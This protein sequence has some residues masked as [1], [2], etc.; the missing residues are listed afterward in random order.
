M[1]GMFWLVLGQFLAEFVVVYSVH[2]L[3]RRV[4][5]A[6]LVKQ[7]ADEDV[8]VR[9]TRA[10]WIVDVGLGTNLEELIEV[11]GAQLVVAA[12]LRGLDAPPGPKASLAD[13]IESSYAASSSRLRTSYVLHSVGGSSPSMSAC[14]K[15]VA[16]AR[17]VSQYILRP[18]SRACIGTLCAF[19]NGE[20]AEGASASKCTRTSAI[21]SCSRS[22]TA[23]CAAYRHAFWPVSIMRRTSL[24]ERSVAR[25]IL[26]LKRGDVRHRVQQKARRVWG[27]FGVRTSAVS[28]YLRGVPSPV[29]GA[30]AA[31]SFQLRDLRVHEVH[32]LGIVIRHLDRAQLVEGVLDEARLRGARNLV[33]LLAFVARC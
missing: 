8:L 33:L 9:E 24:A 5:H 23:R 22:G 1:S 27:L 30:L 7:L 13:M 25:G 20:E 2:I 3:F 14:W 28:A 26:A 29:A 18:E 21:V 15:S 11:P 31:G 19:R 16:A 17:R 12:R 6:L 32:S 10:L 4:L